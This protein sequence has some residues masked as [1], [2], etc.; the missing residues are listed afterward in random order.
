MVRTKAVARCS[1]HFVV[2]EDFL[3]TAEMFKTGCL[4]MEE[5][6]LHKIRPEPIISSN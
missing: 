6:V 5:R 4:E 3:I 2:R 1:L